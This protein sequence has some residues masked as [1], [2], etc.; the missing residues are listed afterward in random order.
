ML[1]HQSVVD[2]AEYTLREKWQCL[3]QQ[4]TT[5]LCLMD[6]WGCG[7]YCM[8]ISLLHCGLGLHGVLH[9]LMTAVGSYVSLSCCFQMVPW[10]HL[11]LCLLAPVIS[12]LGEKGCGNV[13]LLGWT[14]CGLWFYTP[15]LSHVSLFQPTIS[16]PLIGSQ[17][18]TFP[19]AVCKQPLFSGN[20]IVPINYAL[21][22][23][24]Q[25]AM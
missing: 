2:L 6:V 19:L 1:F 8:A 7:G 5:T 4:Q 3:L 22:C 12:E 20:R 17:H 15:W 21:L 16:L 14:V 18:F 10:S 24:C 23:I 13:F 11:H 25:L 9:A